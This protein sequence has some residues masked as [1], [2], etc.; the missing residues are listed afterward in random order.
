MPDAAVR[1]VRNS[2]SRSPSLGPFLIQKPASHLGPAVRWF[3]DMFR[4]GVVRT[5]SPWV[6]IPATFVAR[7]RAGAVVANAAPA[8]CKPYHRR[9]EARSLLGVVVT[10]FQ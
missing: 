6:I 5:L 9:L 10:G 3:T 4:G 8:C 7:V 1:P 2:P